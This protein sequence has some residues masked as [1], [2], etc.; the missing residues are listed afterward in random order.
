MIEDLVTRGTLKRA[1]AYIG[2]VIDDLVTRGTLRM[3]VCYF[4]EG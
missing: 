4:N 3:V 2:V 1:D